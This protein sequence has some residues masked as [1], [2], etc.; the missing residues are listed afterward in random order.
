MMRPSSRP[1]LLALLAVLFLVSACDTDSEEDADG[2]V[3][4]AAPWET[5]P[6][7]SQNIDATALA[8]A[9]ERADAIAGLR[10]L[11][12]VRGGKLVAEAYYDGTERDDLNH[13]R[14]VTKSVISTLVGLAIEDGFISG[15][16]QPITAYLGPYTD[17]LT[18]A[19]RRITIRHLLTMTS[20]FTWDES[21]SAGEFV[22]WVSSPDQVQYL[23]DRSLAHTPGER[24]NYNSAAVHLLSVI[25]TEATGL[26]TEA[27]AR[28]RLFV[29]LGI[30]TWRWEQL[31]GDYQNGGAGLELRARDMAR[32]GVLFVQQGRSGD[33]AVVPAAWAQ[34]ALQPQQELD[35]SNGILEHIDYGYLWWLDA[36]PR[37]RAFLA[38]GY[39]GQFIYGI[40]ELDLVIVSTARWS[41]SGGTA[42]TQER[43]IQS[44]I[45]NHILPA[46]E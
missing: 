27:Y 42:G 7:A 39:G 31:A 35:A 2:R 23:L 33:A 41:V 4:I 19:Q 26:S 8:A 25:L 30:D 36:H 9:Y 22:R 20:G 45:V 17:R 14:S 46:V 6:P 34:A 18:D 28:T 5:V 10:S 15:I 29:P 44:L 21:Y 16:D 1:R 24:F 37:G 13:V 12:V 40:P 11:L 43:A 38:W 3:G 32:L